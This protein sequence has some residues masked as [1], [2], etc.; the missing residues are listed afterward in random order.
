LYSVCVCPE[1]MQKWVQIVTFHV[2]T[3]W[4]IVGTA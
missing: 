1:N 2:V 3:P 4:S